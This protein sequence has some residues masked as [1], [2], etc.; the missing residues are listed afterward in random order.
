MIFFL[1]IRALLAS[2]TFFTMRCASV[3]T[4]AM[5]LGPAFAEDVI[6][7]DLGP[8]RTHHNISKRQEMHLRHHLTRHPHINRR[9]HLFVRVNRPW[10]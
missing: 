7:I 3:L 9:D 2:M 10:K 8:Q 6:G 4:L 1:I 5:W